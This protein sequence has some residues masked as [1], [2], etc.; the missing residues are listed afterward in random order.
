MEAEALA[1]LLGGRPVPVSS[2]KAQIGHTLAAAGAVA[3]AVAVGAIKLGKVPPAAGISHPD[4]TL[5]ITLAAPRARSAPVRAVLVDAFGFGGNDASLVFGA[6]GMGDPADVVDVGPIAITGVT[7][8]GPL[9][10]DADPLRYVDDG[11]IAD[12]S[13]GGDDPSGWLPPELAR[14]ADR[15]GRDAIALALALGDG[16]VEG[17]GVVVGSAFPA[18]DAS[19]AFWARVLAKGPRL[20]PPA[21]FPALVPSS[22]ASLTSIA[23]GARGP[24]LA[25]CELGAT[26]VAAVATAI[27]LLRGGHARS[28]LAIAVEPASP[29]VERVLAPACSRVLAGPRGAGGAAI[30]LEPASRG[31]RAMALVEVAAVCPEPPLVR[32]PRGR[33]AA[34][35]VDDPDA[36]LVAALGWAG[37]PRRSVR[38]RAGW[39]EAAGGFA[40]AAAATAIDRGDLDE[41]LVAVAAPGRFSVCLLVRQ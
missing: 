8:L 15:T 9:G 34:F 28:M 39:H 1:R 33:A 37:V 16:D 21:L 5:A 4:E 26:P 25:V 18:S 35:V 13:R 12:V 20:A 32:G 24:S 30:R 10:R 29:L 7:T 6:A 2:V 41:A 31:R 38:P 40:L 19:A 36:P 27:D 22:A 3:A 14:R 17:L 23:L 11:A